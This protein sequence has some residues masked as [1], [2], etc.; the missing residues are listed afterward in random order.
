LLYIH[1]LPNF[2]PKGNTP[3]LP[4]GRQAKKMAELL[5]PPKERNHILTIL[6]NKVTVIATEGW[7]SFK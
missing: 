2:P 5:Q 4:A 6:T 1:I 3:S 7:I